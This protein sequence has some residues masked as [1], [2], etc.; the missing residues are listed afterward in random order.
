MISREIPGETD[1]GEEKI[2]D[3]LLRLSS[4]MAAGWD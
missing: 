1:A 3:S 4:E 2:R